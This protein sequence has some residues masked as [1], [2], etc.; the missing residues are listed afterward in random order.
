MYE[1]LKGKTA[2]ITGSGKRTG[3]GYAMAEALA[4]SGANV[5]IADLGRGEVIDD[6]L[7]MGAWEE[8]T[9]LAGELAERFGV[10]TLAV[11]VDVT[12]N[13]SIG[14]MVAAVREHFP[15]VDILC[16]NAGAS[17]GVPNTVLTYDEAAWLKTIDVNLHSVFRVSRAVIPLMTG[18]R[19]VIIN[20]AS[21]AGKVPPIFNG[22][23][24][25]AKAG[26]I[27]LSKVMAKELGGWASG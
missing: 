23:Y 3:M 8:M 18:G 26:V 6:D 24:A 13:A 22:A 20:T 5:I 10:K 19:G 12:D 7:K 9:R 15:R 17:F 1:D 14:A 16:N 2:L 27:M 4:G 21:R 25:V 11:P